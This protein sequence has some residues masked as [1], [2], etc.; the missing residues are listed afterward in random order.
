[1]DFGKSRDHI[2]GFERE[3][4]KLGLERM[5]RIMHQLNDPQDKLKFIH[6]AGTNGKGS[7]CAFLASMLTANG[8]KT[9]VYT[10]PAVMDVREQYVIDGKWISDEE[11]AEYASR[12]CAAEVGL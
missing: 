1:M 6:V 9:G 8:Y 7:A 12:V 10:S 5:R 2:E 4:I 3:G 11:Y